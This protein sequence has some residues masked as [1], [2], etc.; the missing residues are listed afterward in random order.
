M[1]VCEISTKLFKKLKLIAIPEIHYQWFFS[2]Y[3]HSQIT[4]EVHNEIY[5]QNTSSSPQIHKTYHRTNIKKF[6]LT[7]KVQG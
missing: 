1:T 3:V 2:Q 5:K 4:S 7:F 6:T